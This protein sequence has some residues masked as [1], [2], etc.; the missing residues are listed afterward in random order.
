MPIYS[1]RFP[2]SSLYSHGMG[3]IGS[4]SSQGWTPLGWKGIRKQNNKYTAIFWTSRS[5]FILLCVL[6]E[7]S[8][9]CL[10]YGLLVL[11][12]TLL[13]DNNTMFQFVIRFRMRSNS[14]SY[15]NFESNGFLWCV[16]ALLLRVIW[17]YYDVNHLSQRS[18]YVKHQV[19]IH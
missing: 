14:D 16:T 4:E 6:L 3:R 12:H 15:F 8:S 7:R 17:L 19:R 11:F 13:K 5:K 10:R 9:C 1:Q 18:P 2:D